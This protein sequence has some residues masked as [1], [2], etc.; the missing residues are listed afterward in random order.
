MTDYKTP[1]F[2]IAI[3]TFRRPE[4]L[5]VALDSA[6][7]QRT[8]V[9]FEVLVIDND[10]ESD[11]AKEI[12]AFQARATS[13]QV[14]YVRNDENIGMFGN[15]NKCLDEA[16]SE[17]MTLLGDDDALHPDF[18]DTIL[19]YCT[20]DCTAIAVGKWEIQ[21]ET[22]VEVLPGLQARS[23]N[24]VRFKKINALLFAIFNPIGTP[25]GFSFNR[26]TALALGGYEPEFYP[27]SDYRFAKRLAGWGTVIT[28][29]S[30]LAFVG[31]GDNASMRAEIMSGFFEK[32]L[33]IRAITPMAL[34][35][36]VG[37]MN[38]AY[39]G[40]QFGF[41][42]SEITGIS[43]LWDWPLSVLGFGFR[44]AKRTMLQIT[45]KRV[46]LKPAFRIG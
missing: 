35:R 33:E 7:E 38:I 22:A 11:F 15:W 19:P 17:W 34:N 31:I 16:R 41:S 8:K 32:D 45:C 36:F 23:P 28:T 27:S 13:A 39:Q 10:P 21:T 1:L 24:P 3:P 18:L 20:V 2:T 40:H 4:L 30:K 43:R 37:L 12:A 25:A 14:R 46:P 5:R 29:N 6:I 26:E 44:V 42:V 9:P